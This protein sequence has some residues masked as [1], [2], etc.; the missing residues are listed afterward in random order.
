MLSQVR[1]ALLM[2]QLLRELSTRLL[3]NVLV[4]ILIMPP[5]GIV[6]PLMIQILSGLLQQLVPIF[7]VL[8]YVLRKQRQKFVLYV[9]T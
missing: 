2:D 8:N 4:I 1:H 5:H 9:K 6:V 3:P 7:P